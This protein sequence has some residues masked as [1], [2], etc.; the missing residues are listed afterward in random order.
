MHSV[1]KHTRRSAFT[2]IETIISISV[3][4]VLFLGLS[5]AVVIGSKA[6]PSSV[7]TG[8]HD[9]QII[10][11]MNRFRDELRQAA[12]IDYRSAAGGVQFILTLNDSGA[13]GAPTTVTYLYQNANQTL[14]READSGTAEDLVTSLTDVES[15]LLMDDK[16]IRAII[17]RFVA[18]DSLQLHY[19]THITLPNKPELL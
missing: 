5:G 9:Q 4:S 17:F 12:T 18:D 11:T 10:D 19:E 15:S 3:M 6:I 7:D 1:S 16:Q 8:T 13:L 14:S 2:L